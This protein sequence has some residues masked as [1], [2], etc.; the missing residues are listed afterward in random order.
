MPSEIII[1]VELIAEYESI[2]E[3]IPNG[4]ET[5]VLPINN[6]IICKKDN[7]LLL[8]V[9]GHPSE[10]IIVNIQALYPHSRTIFIIQDWLQ[11]ERELILYIIKYQI[12][13]ILSENSQDTINKII[14]YIQ[15]FEKPKIES[16]RLSSQ[17]TKTGTSSKIVWQKMLT[18]IK[19]VSLYK[20]EAIVEKYQTLKQLLDVYNR[21]PQ[22]EG[23]ML[24]KELKLSNGRN[25]GKVISKNI[26][27]RFTQT[28]PQIFVYDK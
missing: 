19:G 23:E 26:Y 25:I 14:Q 6:L 10:D 20:A 17:T 24:L 27:N 12:R 18:E 21:I 3:L 5:Q 13:Y 4:V 1:D 7:E 15:N 8:I 16:V 11:N 9:V 28:N 22:S 2:I